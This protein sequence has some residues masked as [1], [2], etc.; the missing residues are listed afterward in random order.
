MGVQ[1]RLVG[2][3]E[4]A[5]P[6]VAAGGD[7][8]LMQHLHDT[9]R[10]IGRHNEAVLEGLPSED[11]WPP[12]CRPMFGWAPANAPM[13][14]YKNRLIHLAASLK[15]MDWELRDWL[16]KFEGL[17]RRLYWESAFVR[18]EGAYLGVSE[19]TWRP[20]RPWVEGLC[21]GRLAPITE[22]AFTSTM[23]AEDLAQL[24]A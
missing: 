12:L 21:R 17:L 20:A 14:A 7:P 9:A 6:G 19:F 18:F 8:T 1:S 13:I 24:R 11:D 2:Y 15:E 10:E 16:D 23:P 4:E 5:W 3:V 22:W